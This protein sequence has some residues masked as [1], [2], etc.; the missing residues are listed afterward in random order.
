MT[1][2]LRL[3]ALP[4]KRRCAPAALA[5][6]LFPAS[7]LLLSMPGTCILQVLLLLLWMQSMPQLLLL[8]SLRTFSG[9]K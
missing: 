2:A 3:P 9:S 5:L 6:V 7:L 4:A 8:L 1:A